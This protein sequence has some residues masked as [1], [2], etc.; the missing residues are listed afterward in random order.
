MRHLIIIFF[1]IFLGPGI[2]SKPIK[3]SSPEVLLTGWNARCLEHAD[4]NK[5]G[6]EDIIYFNL[7]KSYLE[8]LYRCKPNEIPKKVRP[9]KKDRWE[10]K[11]E[12]GSY[13]QERIFVPN[14]ISDIA[15]GD[16]NSDGV[17]DIVTGSP[18]SGIKIYFRL[19]ENEWSEPLKIESEKMRPYSQSLKVVTSKKGSELFIFSELGLERIT[20]LDGQPKYPST[21]FREDDKKAYGLELIDLNEDGHLDWMYLVQGEEYSLKVRLGKNNSFGPELSMDINLASFP[22][23]LIAGKDSSS[24][25][26]CSIDSL[27]REAIVFSF[28]NI[29]KEKKNAYNISTYDI[30]E[31]SNKESSWTLGDFD[32]DGF[33]ELVSVSAG[34][35]EIVFF[36][37]DKDGFS[38]TVETFP[39]FR[40]ISDISL[41]NHEDKAHLLI[42][43][44]EEEVLGLSSYD[45]N[46]GFS[47]P[48][49]INLEGIPI[50]AS[51]HDS[52]K[53]TILIICEE[54]SNYYLKTLQL[55][56]SGS[57]EEKNSL[58][59]NDLKRE[60]QSLFQCD[61]NGDSHSDVMVLSSRDA[62]LILLGE[63]S[64]EWTD[65]SSN[66][67][68]RKSFLKNVDSTK[69]GKFPD[70]SLNK[71]SLLVAG[72]GF[73]REIGWQNGELT[74]IQ[75]YN[76]KD[77]GSE[78][79]CPV[80]MDWDQDGKDEV[81]AFNE[82]G[83][84]ERLKSGFADSNIKNQ[85]DGSFMEPNHVM[86]LE[87]KKDA[88]LLVLGNS[89]FQIITKPD[90]KTLSVNI[91]SKYLTDLPKIRYNG[92][93]SGDFNNDGMPDLVCL[94]GKKSLLEFL[95]FNKK[96]NIWKSS[97]HFEVFEKNL[98]Y[99]G[100]KGGLFEPREG[101]VFD[102]NGDGL[103][104][105]V[106]LVHNRL[107]LYKQ[108]K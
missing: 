42:V 2:F 30:F 65:S 55:G 63:K 69:L 81:F 37:S 8:I 95:T 93:E 68:V 38:G 13:I 35:G 87:S 86:V 108:T 14:S 57:Y 11:L 97:L 3:L 56:N 16:L 74:I 1:F 92:I 44:P 17:F 64:G 50:L 52:E 22:T 66:S 78:L 27:S 91:E 26:F 46:K 85:W 102:A 79:S 29:F 20:F 98:H 58:H 31:K 59:L 107:L 41:H 51:G 47:F 9:V 99:Q 89:G 34:K 25:K 28:S 100:K 105:L 40:G 72:L 83:H 33:N 104:D 5:D 106:F 90:K 4:L 82:N 77:Q 48:K 7:D 80:R 96:E 84:W 43:S 60:P 12:N 70:S 75:Q 62:P 15:V 39:S 94:D 53:N 10:P 21:I 19:E 88:H 24:A 36:Q 76:S 71:D 6:M 49:L 73:V 32:D 54:D 67:V 101:L 18:Q 45:E 103:D 23:K 61:L